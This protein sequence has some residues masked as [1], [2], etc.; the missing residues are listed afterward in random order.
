MI[1]GDVALDQ[2]APVITILE[3]ELNRSINYVIYS[4]DEWNEKRTTN[5]PFWENV[6]NSLKIILIGENHAL[7]QIV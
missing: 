7:R 6:I 4:E 5:D 3:K 1:V 2:L